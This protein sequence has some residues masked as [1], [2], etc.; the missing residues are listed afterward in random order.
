VTFTAEQVTAMRDAVDGFLL[1]YRCAL[2]EV[3][4]SPRT[5]RD[6]FQQMHDYNPVE[7]LSCRL[8]SE[9]SIINKVGRLGIEP[10][11]VH[12]SRSPE[13]QRV[14][15]SS[16][17][18]GRPVPLHRE[19]ARPGRDPVRTIAMDF[20]ASLE[21]KIHYKYDG[22]V[23]DAFSTSSGKRLRRRPSSTCACS[24]SSSD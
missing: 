22:N 10:D 8:K 6:E 16:R 9:A 1:E 19:D 23:P 24:A 20:W 18:R 17:D 15:E 21:H 5:L 7:H 4:T 12:I 3:E 11:L 13:C 2:R 14:Q